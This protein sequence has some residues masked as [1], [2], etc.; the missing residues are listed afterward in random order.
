[1]IGKRLA[2]VCL[3]S[4]AAFSAVVDLHAADCIK[5]AQG[6]VVCGKGPCAVDQYGAI[7]C[8]KE[9]GGAVRDRYGVVRCGLG[10]CAIDD[11]GHVK[12]S[13][14]PGGGAMTDSYGKVKCL[15]GCED[16]TPQLCES[17]R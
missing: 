1:M 10:A 6:N 4:L 16:G 8:A 7:F 9:G 11:M 15:D 5:D 14:K 13:S 2:V 12:C 3:V 17:A